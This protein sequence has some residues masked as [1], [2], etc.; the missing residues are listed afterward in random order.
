MF[1]ANT[2]YM[3]T[4]YSLVLATR[5]SGKV[6][7][8]RSLL[9]QL[10]LTLHAVSDFPDAPLVEEDAPTLKGNAH[11]K[12]EA[13]FIHTGFAA[14]ADDTGLEVEA[15]DGQPGVHSARFASPDATD[16]DNRRHLLAQLDGHG[17]RAARFRTVIAFVEQEGTHYFEG[18][19]EGH[20]LDAERGDGGFGYDA[21]FQPVGYDC[22]FAEL[23][24]EEKNAISHRGRAVR[25]FVAFLQRRYAR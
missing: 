18:V 22:T 14:L 20:I 24:R 23:S 17:N 2:L 11:K 6:K 13:L 3:H 21:L 25:A 12:A 16:G 7:E 8:M 10:P 1:T 5:N 9:N 19:C 15:L 4:R